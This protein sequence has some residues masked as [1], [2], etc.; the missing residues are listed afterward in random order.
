MGKNRI[1]KTKAWRQTQGYRAN[2][3][4]AV[5]GTGKDKTLDYIVAHTDG[6]V[7]FVQKGQ[8]Q[9]IGATGNKS[10][11]NF[12]KIKHKGGYHT[13]YAHMKN[14]FIKLGQKVKRGQTLGYMGNTGN[15]YGSHL[16]FEVWKKNKRINPTSYINKDLPD[17]PT[18]SKNTKNYYK[19]YR[20]KS[21]SLVDALKS[22]GV[23]SS[24]SNRFKIAKKN[25]IKSYVG[26]SSQNTKLLNLLKKGKLIK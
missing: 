15:S 16:H 19:K 8:K 20:G 26:T 12:V 13:L 21:N 25:G 4:Q 22:I 23:N 3:H 7:E 6:E 5:D 11:G 2:G 10:Y 1:L 18:V 14:V 9:N 24:F 17:N